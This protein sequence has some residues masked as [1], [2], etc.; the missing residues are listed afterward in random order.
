[1]FRG[2]CPP[3]ALF[4]LD[5]RPPHTPTINQ[6]N[7]DLLTSASPRVAFDAGYLALA[8]LLGVNS[9]NERQLVEREKQQAQRVVEQEAAARG[10]G[11]SSSSDGGGAQ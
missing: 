11:G 4:A 9:W 3:S 5:T 6:K 8:T 10:S 7:T 1:M 2:R